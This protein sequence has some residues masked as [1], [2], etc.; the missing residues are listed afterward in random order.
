MFVTTNTV[1]I[2]KRRHFVGVATEQY[3][4]CTMSRF[5]RVPMNCPTAIQRDIERKTHFRKRKRI[6]RNLQETCAQTSLNTNK[7]TRTTSEQARV[8]VCVCVCKRMLF[9]VCHFVLATN[10]LVRERTTTAAAKEK[11]PLP[12]TDRTGGVAV[13]A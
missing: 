8:H 11:Q 9:Q 12:R 3:S 5:H 10:C 6:R 7:R 4:L 2:C 1:N 13:V